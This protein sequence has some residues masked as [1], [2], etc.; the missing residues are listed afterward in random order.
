VEKKRRK[1]KQKRRKITVQA[2]AAL[3]VKLYTN[4]ESRKEKRRCVLQ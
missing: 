1:N 4:K 3:F 2:K